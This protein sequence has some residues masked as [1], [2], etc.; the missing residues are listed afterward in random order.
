MSCYDCTNTF[1]VYKQEV[2]LIAFTII[3]QNSGET[4]DGILFHR[5]ELKSDG[6][7]PKDFRRIETFHNTFIESFGHFAYE[8]YSY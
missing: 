4:L 7:A 2:T 5:P 6:S 1:E 8:R 3:S